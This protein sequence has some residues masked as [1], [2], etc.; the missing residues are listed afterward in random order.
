MLGVQNLIL[1]NALAFLAQILWN[2]SQETTDSKN[3]DISMKSHE[4]MKIHAVQHGCSQHQVECPE[5]EDQA[6]RWVG[7]VEGPL[8]F[9]TPP[10]SPETDSASARYS[11]ETRKITCKS[12]FLAPSHAS[13]VRVW[14]VQGGSPMQPS[15]TSPELS[16]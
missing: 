7:F 13:G 12:T 6:Q 15:S 11:I 10:K 14:S 9:P 5:C 3:Y 8:S 2:C 16:Y 4:C 1:A